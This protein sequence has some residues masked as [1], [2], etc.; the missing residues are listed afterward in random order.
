ML[1]HISVQIS[2]FSRRPAGISD[3]PSFG[4]PLLHTWSLAV[5]EQY[6]LIWPM[7]MLLAFHFSGT[8]HTEGFMRRRALW[9]LGA[10]FATSLALSI[11]TTKDHQSFA[12]FLLPARIWEFAIGGMVGLAGSIFYARLRR[13]AEV[14]A[15]AGLALIAYSVVA[16]DHSTPFPGWAAIFPVLGTVFL[17]AGMTADEDGV[18]R[19]MLS[20]K[21]MVFIG[22]LSY[23]WYLWH[24]PLLSL[25]RIY[26]L[27]FQDV[28]ANAVIIVLA[29]VLAWLTYVLIENPIRIRRPGPFRSVRPTLFAGLG[30]ALL[31]VSMGS[32]LKAWRD[33][34]KTLEVNQPIVKARND[35]APL[36]GTCVFNANKP[37]GELPFEKCIHGSGKGVPKVLLWGDSHADHVMP[38]LIEAY[39]DVA[40]YQLTMA[41]CPPVI[42][43]ELKIPP[44]SKFCTEFNRQVLLKIDELKKDGLT[45]VVISARWPIYLWRRAIAVA[46]EKPSLA[47]DPQKMAQ[48]RIEMQS[49]FDETLTMLERAGLRVLVLAPNPE[50][51][52]SPPLCI[53]MRRGEH[54]NVPR[55]IIEALVNDPTETLAEVVSR[56]SN[57]RLAQV[58]EFFCDAIASCDPHPLRR[59]TSC[60]WP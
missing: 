7:I 26:N 24:W 21:P 19:R 2:I 12:F 48:A 25:Y 20:F 23:S 54:C 11:G 27:G 43:F 15:V 40:V 44:V 51:I 1:S 33:Y 34:Q 30:I 28:A 16:L 46:E 5:E 39:P 14:L 35:Y 17:I 29:L 41:G 4:M 8:R 9:V 59:G 36:R 42:G 50:M 55:S 32:G 45:G 31:T 52:Y 18:V 38:A 37:L 22:L 56:H 10:M 60:R 57:V 3:D 13:W 49:S 6:Y 53:G 58:M 47:G